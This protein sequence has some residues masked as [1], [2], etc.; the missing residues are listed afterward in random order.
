MA[1]ELGQ[2]HTVETTLTNLTSAQDNQL[3]YMFD[4]PGQLSLQLQRLIRQG[5]YFKLVGID[6]SLSSD[7]PN[8]TN[9]GR[10]S[11]YIRYL[12]PTQG[13]CAAYRHAF[14]SMA[15]IMKI[16]G[17][18]MRD[19]VGYDFRCS[20]T[21]NPQLQNALDNQATL[22][23]TAGLALIQ[24]SNPGASVFGVY[25]ES[26]VNTIDPLS[27]NMFSEGFD[28]IIQNRATGTDFVL[29]DTALY[30][31]N[32]LEASQTFEE[33]PFQLA[34]SDDAVSPTF[35]FRP[36]PALFI[37]MMCGLAEIRFEQVDSIDPSGLELQVSFMIA[38][39]KSIMGEP[40]KKNTRR[41][42]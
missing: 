8:P 2:I 35:Q 41:M 37:A 42:N 6:M 29:N 22:D 4:I 12:A 19:N 21:D 11:G 32:E 28:T 3:H 30:S 38:G 24:A 20:L 25:N 36:D 26:I 1:K 14:K 18:N 23:G 39:W 7:T 15:D 9:G 34:F 13:R 27:P 40:G 17:I 16:Q 10:I 33:I 31:G 5:N